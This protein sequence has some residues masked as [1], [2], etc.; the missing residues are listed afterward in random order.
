[1][2]LTP[3]YGY[4]VNLYTTSYRPLLKNFSKRLEHWRIWTTQ[5]SATRDLIEQYLHGLQI[6]VKRI[7]LRREWSSI[8]NP[9]CP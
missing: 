8:S 4:G 2:P 5:R 6:S 1:M 7:F 9:A 3:H